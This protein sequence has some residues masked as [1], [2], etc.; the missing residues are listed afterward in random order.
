MNSSKNTLSAFGFDRQGNKVD[1][2]IFYKSKGAASV[3]TLSEAPSNSSPTKSI[4]DLVKQEVKMPEGL[5]FRGKY[6]GQ[7]RSKKPDEQS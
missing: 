6:A 4:Y 7:S 5:L 3:K 2:P 1:Q